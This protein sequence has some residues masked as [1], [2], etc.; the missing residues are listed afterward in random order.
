ML[1]YALALAMSVLLTSAAFAGTGYEV[2]SKDGD[3]TVT[4]KVK[5]GGG[6]RFQQHTAYDPASKEFVY[7]TWPRGEEGPKPVCSIWNHQTGR[8][9]TLYPFPGAKHPLPVIPSIDAM[10]V[11]PKTGDEDFQY[12]RKIAYD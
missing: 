7:L 8:T 4:Y 5:F 1:R 3:E 9:I 2:T 6:K 10:K 11:C 12:Q